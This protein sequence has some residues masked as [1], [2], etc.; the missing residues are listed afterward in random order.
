MANLN[1]FVEDCKDK[2]APIEKVVEELLHTRE[3]IP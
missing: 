1:Q 3:R 2:S